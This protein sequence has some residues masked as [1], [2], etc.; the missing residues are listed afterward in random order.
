MECHTLGLV[1]L[2]VVV[3]AGISIQRQ[4]Q[5]LAAHVRRAAQDLALATRLR[6]SDETVVKQQLAICEEEIEQG[7][8]EMKEMKLAIDD[9]IASAPL[10]LSIVFAT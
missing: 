1:A 2:S 5:A 8:L 10:D 6:R 9:R 7:R 4:R 3:H